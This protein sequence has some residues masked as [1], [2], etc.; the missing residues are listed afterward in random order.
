MNYWDSV[1][2][3]KHCPAILPGMVDVV[4]K[5]KRSEIMAAVRSR[6]NKN[7]EA[8]LVT[9]FRAAGLVGWRRHQNLPGRPDFVFSRNRVAVFVDGCFWHGCHWHCRMPKTRTAYW[10][11]KI[12]RNKDRDREVIRLLRQKG[13]RVY[14]IW[15]HSL[16]DPE[17]IVVKIQALLKS[18]AQYT[19]VPATNVL[20]AVAPTSRYAL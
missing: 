18:D 20:K 9:V 11:P 12:A 19:R 2:G 8:R 10:I 6:G 1:V 5:A 16:K 13:W 17:K 15:E 14:R 3:S 7:T 4:T